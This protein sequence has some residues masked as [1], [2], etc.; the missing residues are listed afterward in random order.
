MRRRAAIAGWG[1]ALLALAGCALARSRVDPAAP[2]PAQTARQ[3]QLSQDAQAAIDRRDYQQALAL[4]GQL[5]AEAPQSPEVRHRLAKVFQLQGQLAEAEAEYRRALALDPEYVGAL[6]G[7]GEIEAAY[8]RLDAALQRFD[9]AIEIDPREPEGHY[10]Q[11]RV[12]ELLRRTDDA[13]AAYFRSLELDPAQAAVNLRVAALQLARREPDQALR[14]LDQVVELTP[15]DPEAHH[16]RG[17]THLSLKHYPQAVA[18]FQFAARRLPNRP[19]VFSHLALALDADHQRGLA[20][21]AAEHALRL[22]PN[23]A[24]ARD[25]SRRLRR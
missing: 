5:V 7:L 11:G 6:I 21:Q 2:S 4:L 8:G 9:L 12:F 1:A 14:R 17:L 3:Q 13:L 10:G 20:L 19:D 24:V 16:L 23:D 18:D 22:A 15:N 25:L